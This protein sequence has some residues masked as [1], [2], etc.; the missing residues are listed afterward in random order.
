[1]DIPVA[2][3][4]S[5]DFFLYLPEFP[6]LPQTQLNDLDFGTLIHLVGSSEVPT[7]AVCELSAVHPAASSFYG[8]CT[9]L[10]IG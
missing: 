4:T 5:V 8:A 6:P 9:S 7:T 10:P 2:T 3:W 1:M